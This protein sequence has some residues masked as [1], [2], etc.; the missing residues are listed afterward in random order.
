MI[1]QQGKV[2]AADAG[3]ISVRLGASTGCSACDAGKG[4]G[5][6]VFGRLLQR[7]P[8][9]LDFENSIGAVPGQAVMVGLPE[10]L[11]MT[12]VLRLYAWPI[13][14]GLA[15]AVLGYLAAA[16]LGADRWVSDLATLSGGLLAAAQVMR[17]V[18][19]RPVEFSGTAAVHLLRK[20]ECQGS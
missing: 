5:A 15:G 12:L 6:G 14:A 19:K 4:C 2:V 20:T 7:K 17:R 16:G 18:R 9:T 11:F 10:T 13:L 1:E 8:V 3:Q